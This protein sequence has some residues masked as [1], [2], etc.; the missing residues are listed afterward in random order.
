MKLAPTLLNTTMCRYSVRDRV[1]IQQVIDVYNNLMI[2]TTE[3]QELGDSVT[4]N[5]RAK[6]TLICLAD[7]LQA[8][9]VDGEEA[10]D[11]LTEYYSV[12]F[13]KDLIDNLRTV[14]KTWN[15]QEFEVVLSETLSDGQSIFNPISMALLHYGRNPYDNVST[16]SN[17]TAISRVTDVRFYDEGGASLSINSLA[18]PFKFTFSHSQ[19]LNLTSE[20]GPLLIGDAPGL[21][22]PGGKPYCRYWDG[23]KWSKDGCFAIE[24]DQITSTS[25]TCRC[26]HATP[27]LVVSE[28]QPLDSST[29]QDPNPRDPILPVSQNM[30]I[31]IGAG[32]GIL[33]ILLCLLCLVCCCICCCLCLL[34]RMC[35][36]KR[37]RK[38]KEKQ[39]AGHI[40]SKYA[41]NPNDGFQKLKTSSTLFT[42][43]SVSD[44]DNLSGRTSHSN[45]KEY[46]KDTVMNFDQP[47]QKT[48]RNNFLS[49]DGE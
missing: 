30:L 6:S 23:S 38:K 7:H 33:L 5:R 31:A 8:L 15:V 34:C 20:F 42:S 28:R 14:S 21:Q 37:R 48:M 1:S 49:F 2:S 41:V 39:V 4:V 35:I 43:D 16:P 40:P 26:N 11:I 36:M 9:H 46:S 47:H 22:P 25:I 12:V 18:E 27:F 24:D 44:E 32:A 45:E 19:S 3:N 29:D 13:Y 10:T 17:Y